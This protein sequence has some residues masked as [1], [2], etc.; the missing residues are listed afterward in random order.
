M[1]RHTRASP[2]RTISIVHAQQLSPS[3]TSG[4]DNTS[5]ESAPHDASLPQVRP[6][7]DSAAQSKFTKLLL[8]FFG[9]SGGKWKR[10]FLL[11]VVLTIVLNGYSVAIATYSTFGANPATAMDDA[12]A[13]MQQ[14]LAQEFGSGSNETI[15]QLVELRQWEDFNKWVLS[16]AAYAVLLPSILSLT[17]EIPCVLENRCLCLV[18]I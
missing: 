17:A 5:S 10:V 3:P 16:C 18:S 6:A 11:H 4:D 9:F 1:H 15:T 8:N 12:I 14:V 7:A 13:R 2:Y